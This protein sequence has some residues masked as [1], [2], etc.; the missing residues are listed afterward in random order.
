MEIK[1]TQVS[2][3]LT[4]KE[5]ISQIIPGGI[6]INSLP[7]LGPMRVEQNSSP[8]TRST[9]GIIDRSEESI[10]RLLNQVH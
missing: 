5:V 1:P 7:V 9:M 2:H 8:P 10:S 6:N 4:P 3:Q